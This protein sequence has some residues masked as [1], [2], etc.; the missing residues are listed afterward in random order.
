MPL[1]E[2]DPPRVLPRGTGSERP[3]RFGSGSVSN[4]QL[5]RGLLRSFMKPTGTSIHIESSG[6]PAS[7]SRTCACGSSE[8]RLA[9]TQP[10][11]PP[12]TIMQS[13]SDIARSSPALRPE[14]GFSS[15]RR[16]P[17]VQQAPDASH[18]RMPFPIR[19]RLRERD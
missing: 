19:N 7:S 4:R 12:P 2:L 15:D 5:Y 8:M 9:I 10:A 16:H 3:L 18:G 13:Y 6:G 11:E 1:I 14:L 17:P